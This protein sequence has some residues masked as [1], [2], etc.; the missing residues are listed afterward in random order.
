MSIFN[1]ITLTDTDYVE[2]TFNELA[3]WISIYAHPDNSANI[4]VAE[5][6]DAVDAESVELAPSQ[7]INIDFRSNSSFKIYIKWTVDDKICYITR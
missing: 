4:K 7:A 3:Q 1:T 6:N 5:A 2:V